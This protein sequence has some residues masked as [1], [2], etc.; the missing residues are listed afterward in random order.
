MGVSWRDGPVG[1]RCAID[2][3][4]IMLFRPE[5]SSGTEPMQLPPNFQSMPR[6]LGSISV[7]L[8]ANA[9]LVVCNGSDRRRSEEPTSEL[10]SLMRISY[11]VLCLKK[12]TK[13]KS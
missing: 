8:R 10:Q 12:Q 9:I 2:M 5:R 3:R 1:H 13:Y 11:A 4:A 6:R 7:I